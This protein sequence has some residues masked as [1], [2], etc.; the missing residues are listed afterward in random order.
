MLAVNVSARQFAQPD[1]VDNT[2]ATLRASGA[3][4]DRLKLELTE[5]T[6]LESIGE[7]FHKM[8]SLKQVGITFS[9]D[10]FG[11]GSSSLSY[12]MRLPLDTLKIDKSFVDDLPDDSQDLRRDRRDGPSADPRSLRRGRHHI[13]DRVGGMR[14]RSLDVPQGSRAIAQFALLAASLRG[15]GRTITLTQTIARTRRAAVTP[16]ASATPPGTEPP[17]SPRRSGRCL[18]ADSGCSYAP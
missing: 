13:S 17:D 3:P 15:L 5:S 4:A 9:L 18:H 2:I 6:V 1:F 8:Q 14:H 7:A 16:L 10:D 11:T 12:L